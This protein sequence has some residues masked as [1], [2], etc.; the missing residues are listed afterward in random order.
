[1]RSVR[2]HYRL[3]VHIYLTFVYV[4]LGLIAEQVI[5]LYMFLDA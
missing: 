2:R 3:D 5:C 4:L 1:M